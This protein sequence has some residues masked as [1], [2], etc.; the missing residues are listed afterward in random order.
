MVDKF[1]K[2]YQTAYPSDMIQAEV[3]KFLLHH[4]SL[5]QPVPLNESHSWLTFVAKEFYC[6]AIFH[7]RKLQGSHCIEINGPHFAAS[8]LRDC[9]PFPS[10]KSEKFSASY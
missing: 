9:I 10:L 3:S 8:I 4:C 7:L 6:D 5:Y 2:N 1:S